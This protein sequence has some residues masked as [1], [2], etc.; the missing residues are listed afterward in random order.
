MKPLI[1]VTADIDDALRFSKRYAG[2]KL[3]HLWEA[4]LQAVRDSGG[5]P[6][7]IAPSED[8]SEMALLLKHLN[9]I[10]ISGGAFDVPP[11]FY[12]EKTIRGAKVKPKPERAKFEKQL[13]IAAC[14]A[15]KPILGI[16]GG[17]QIINVA[18]GGT[19]FQDLP[20]QCQ[21]K[22]QHNSPSGRPIARHE[23]DVEP[24]SLLAQ[25]LFPKPLT[26]IKRI[27]VNS[28]HHQAVKKMG[29]GLRMAATSPDGLIEAIEAE[30]GFVIG[31]QWHPERMYRESHEQFRLLCQFIKA[32]KAS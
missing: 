10:L 26:S 17:E 8:P 20:L 7:L 11:S 21:T 31:V 14:K 12:G 5:A 16:C 3:V 24:D 4:Y 25:A 9:G 1:G 23:V 22:N 2:K 32:A 15:G 28:S 27:S 29:K 6:V 18:F 13:V 19:L 30:N